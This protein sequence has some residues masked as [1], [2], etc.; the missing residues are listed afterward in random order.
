MSRSFRYFSPLS[1]CSISKTPTSRD[2]T[3]QPENADSSIKSSTSE[4]VAVVRL[5][6]GQKTEVV[7]KRQARREH[8]TE[9]EAILFGVVFELISSPFG[10]FHHDLHGLL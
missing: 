4:R 1:A 10:S 5:C 7:R 6:A 9:H 2:S 3:R 8:S